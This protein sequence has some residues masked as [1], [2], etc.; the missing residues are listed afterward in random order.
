MLLARCVLGKLQVHCLV[1]HVCPKVNIQKDNGV[2]MK[3]IG[4]HVDAI[5]IVYDEDSYNKRGRQGRG[6][7]ADVVIGEVD[8]GDAVDARVALVL[9]AGVEADDVLL[10][11]VGQLHWS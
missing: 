1:K 4:T 7:A 10:C 5:K 2:R 6:V 9:D 8:G 3:I 11:M